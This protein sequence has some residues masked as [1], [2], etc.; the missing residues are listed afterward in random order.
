MLQIQEKGVDPEKQIDDET[1]VLD[2]MALVRKIKTSGR[3]L[4]KYQI[5]FYK[6]SLIRVG[7]QGEL[8]DA[9]RDH[10]IKKA[11]RTRRGSGTLLFQNLN[12][13]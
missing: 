2:G 11:E 4:V 6:E 3:H 12:P 7:I 1:T 8:F 10:S 9:Y 13:T 5:Y